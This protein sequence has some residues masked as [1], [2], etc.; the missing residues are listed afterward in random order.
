MYFSEGS[1]YY[2]GGQILDYRDNA[3]MHINGSREK[4]AAKTV[5]CDNK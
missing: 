3:C 5:S 2:I 4:L 1:N